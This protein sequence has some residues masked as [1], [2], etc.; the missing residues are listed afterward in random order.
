[1]KVVARLLALVIFAGGSL[2]ATPVITDEA[3]EQAIVR[4]VKVTGTVTSPRTSLLSPSVGGLVSRIEVDVGD[5]VAPGDLLLQL[6]PELEVL[7]LERSRAA[8]AEARSAL[9]DA[10][11]R[12]REAERLEG[13]NSIAQTEVESRRTEVEIA[14]AALASATAD[15]RQ[16]EAVVRRHAVRAPFAGVVSQRLT[17]LGEWVNPGVGVFEL[18]AT[19][20]LRFDFRVPQDVYPA[21]DV[22]TAIRIGLDASPDAEFDATIQAIVPVNE[23]PAR[24][25]LLRAVVTDG[26]A[27]GVTPGMSARAT[28]SIDT[29]RRAVVAPR[30]ALLRYP[31]GR[32]T[33]WT[34]AREPT[35]ATVTERRIT[36]GLEFDGLVE[37]L[38]GLEAGMEVVTR[39]N[40]S[41]QDGQAVTLP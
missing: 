28:L 35:G 7:A 20:G 9:T 36:T 33:V 17:E 13:D 24:T 34:V 29:G 19:E 8:E 4:T 31:D 1:M 37:V 2:H 30:D 21:I 23:P 22:T 14:V 5:R 18:V 15:V 11:R 39:G 25:F 6:D 16:R 27:P 10:R 41:L 40:E 3:R 26:V 12:L 32:T 38:E